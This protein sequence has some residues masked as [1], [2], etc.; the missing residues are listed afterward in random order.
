MLDLLL[1]LIETIDGYFPFGKLI[2]WIIKK[3]IRL[4]IKYFFKKLTSRIKQRS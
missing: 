1:N 4:L 3:L 2:V